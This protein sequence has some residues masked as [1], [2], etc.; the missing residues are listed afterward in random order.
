MLCC[1]YSSNLLAAV[2]Y[3]N[4]WIKQKLCKFLLSE[5]R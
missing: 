3:Q 1:N 2:Q 4:D 5:T